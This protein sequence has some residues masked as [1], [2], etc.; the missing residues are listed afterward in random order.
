MERSHGVSDTLKIGI[1]GT[2]G[3]AQAHLPAL[4]KIQGVEVVAAC[5]IREEALRSTAQKFEIPKTF[6]DYNDLLALK[7]VKAVSI[8]TPNHVHAAPTIAAFKAGKHVIVEKPMAMNAKEAKAMLDASKRAKKVLVVG[9]QYRYTPNAQVIKRAIDDGRLGKILYC[10]CQALRRRG[11]PSWG[12]FGQK[13]LQGG[14]PMIDIGVH[15]IEVAHYLMGTPEPVS[16]S[17][18]CYTYLGNKK[19]DAAC[20]WG[21]WDYKTYTVEDLAVGIIR[22]SNGATL[23]IESSFAAHI[24][25]DIFNFTLMGD[26]GGA[27]YDPPGI[28]TDMSGTMFNVMPA[29]AGKVDVWDIKMRDWVDSIR[30]G[31][32][33]SVPGEHGLIV[34]KMLDGIYRSA[35]AGKEVVIK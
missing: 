32:Q 31:R 17:G 11:I 1:I 20:S 30:T 10:R 15:I 21:T 9:F 12:V 5:D 29:F 22:F 34:Q 24:D 19:P 3:I 35:A 2:G 18:A 27:T 4:K 16:A 6:H 33:P 13:E 14:G 25:K 23:V 26:K 8:C 7:E 28:Y